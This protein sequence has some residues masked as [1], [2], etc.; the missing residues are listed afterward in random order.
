LS[1]LPAGT[2]SVEARSLG[3]APA[4]A[5]VDLS[6]TKPAVVYIELSKKAQELENVV[7]QG[8]SRAIRPDLLEFLDRKRRG[9]GQFLT[10]DN[11]ELKHAF[12]LVDALRM[13]P[14][15]TI[16]PSGKFGHVILMHGGCAANVYL[17]GMRMSDATETVDD[18]PPNQIAGIEIY[19]TGIGVPARF[20]QWNGCGV[21]LLWTKH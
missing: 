18:I 2:F 21:V 8:R 19:D 15:I 11:L 13:S 5:N 14:G 1:G 12:S 20:L 6:P 16:M 3:M 10:P 17:D 7:V 9:V 4:S